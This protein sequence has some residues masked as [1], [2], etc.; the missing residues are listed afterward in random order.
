MRLGRTIAVML[1]AFSVAMGPV[2]GGIAI[3]DA[4]VSTTE[5]V[6]ASTHDCCDHDGMPT[7]HKNECQAAAGCFSKC[8]NFCGVT[9]SSVVA[10][11]YMGEAEPSPESQTFRSQIGNPP[12]RPPRV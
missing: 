8:F 3:T 6:A 4:V 12:F 5:L 7:S 10:P 11:L 1:I 9:L 2:A